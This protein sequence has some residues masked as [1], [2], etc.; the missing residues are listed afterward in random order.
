MLDYA[1]FDAKVLPYI[2]MKMMESHDAGLNWDAVKVFEGK[3]M[4]KSVFTKN[5]VH[6]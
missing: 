2:L 1:G 6:I 3:R 5:E 4:V